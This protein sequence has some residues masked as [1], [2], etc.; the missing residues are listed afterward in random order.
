MSSPTTEIPGRI[1]DH[2]AAVATSLFARQ[3]G[4]GSWQDRLS[5]SAVVTATS[6]VGLHFADPDGSAD[7]IR[8]GADWLRRTQSPDGGWGDAPGGP[9]TLIVTP[10]AVGALALV[11]PDESADHVRRGLAWIDRAGG[12]RAV[13]D[14]EQCKLSVMCEILLALGGLHDERKIRRMPIEVVHL[15]RRMQHRMSFIMPILYSWG[16]MQARTRRFSLPRR[17]LNRRATPRIRQYLSQIEEYHGSGAGFQDSPLMVSLVCLGLSRAG[18]WPDIVGRCVDYLRWSARPDGSWSVNRCLNFSA[19]SWVTLGLQTA[20]YARDPRLAPALAWMADAQRRDSFAATGAPPGGWG[21][22][23]PGGWVDSDD[24]ADALLC[25]AAQGARP[26]SAAVQAGVSW[27]LAM[28][29]RNGS[30]SCFCPDS[31]LGL[32]APCAA[33]TAHAVSALVLAGRLRPDDDAVGKAIRWFDTVQQP[34]GAIAALWYRGLTAGTGSVLETLGQLGLSDTRTA[35]RCRDWLIGHQQADGGWG[36]GRGAPS[37]AEE[38]AWA[39]LGLLAAGPG[40]DH[41]AV[42]SGVAWL[43]SRQRPDGLW[44]PSM[45]GFYFFDLSYSNDLLAAGYALQALASYQSGRSGR[46]PSPATRR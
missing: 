44:E 41:P 20:G 8:A 24:T 40:P 28:Q 12:M 4:D 42:E 10:S 6:V 1:E 45:V 35:Q 27:L 23:V 14:P 19:T 36:D 43:V 25:L 29:S 11:A 7:L 17:L 26:D 21:W 3:R 5:S 46:E 15:P 34:D 22:S 38:T 30:W 13:S 32:D 18:L 33:M 39:L 16:L 2:I 9:S 37:T 31:R